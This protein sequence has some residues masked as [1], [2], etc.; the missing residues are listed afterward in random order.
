MLSFI[1]TGIFIS[2]SNFRALFRSVIIFCRYIVS[3]LQSV[4]AIYSASVLERATDFCSVTHQLIILSPRVV[5]YPVV[6][7]RLSVQ[8]PQS[9]SL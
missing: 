9:E 2:I 7:L 4:I 8:F 6:N 1:I 3:L 5:I